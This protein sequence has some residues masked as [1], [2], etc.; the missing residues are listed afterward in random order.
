M[1]FRFFIREIGVIRGSFSLIGFRE[2][3]VLAALPT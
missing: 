2:S 1:F 3:H